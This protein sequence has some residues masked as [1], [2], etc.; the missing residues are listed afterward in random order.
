MARYSLAGYIIRAKINGQYAQLGSVN[1]G[2]SIIDIFIIF[3]NYFNSRIS[4]P[5]HDPTGRKLLRATHFEQRDRQL[6]GIIETGE[7]GYES[8]LYN[9]GTGNISYKRR[10]EDA[11]MLPFYFMI[12]L[13]QHANEGILL[14]QRFKQFGIRTIFEKD[15]NRYI[16]DLSYPL[17]LEINPLVPRQLVE[18]YLKGRIVKLRFIR[19]GWPSDITDAY[20]R[21]GHYEEE[22]YTELVISAKKRGNIPVLE[23]IRDFLNNFTEF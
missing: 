6:F 4:S 19:F 16:K 12:Y 1:I 8:E 17:K 2:S 22:G 13:P 21:Q 9:V 23:K 5:S 10:I 7:Y 11:E 20:D 3:Q 15:V 14:L 18:K